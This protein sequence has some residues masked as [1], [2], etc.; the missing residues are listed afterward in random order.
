MVLTVILRDCED[1]GDNAASVAT[2]FL[3]WAHESPCWPIQKRQAHIQRTKYNLLTSREHGNTEEA[4]ILP[5]IAA[6]LS[7]SLMGC[8]PPHY[9]FSGLAPEK[10]VLLP[11]SSSLAS[12]EFF[13]TVAMRWWNSESCKEEAKQ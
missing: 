3:L 4:S 6:I 9:C 13:R 2:A 5:G 11:H 1:C 8:I 12:G 7:P 10:P